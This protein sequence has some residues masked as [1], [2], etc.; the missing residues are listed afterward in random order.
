MSAKLSQSEG[1]ASCKPLFKAGILVRNSH[2]SVTSDWT[3]HFS[4]TWK[5]IVCHSDWM[6][7]FFFMCQKHISLSDWL[8]LICIHSFLVSIFSTY[9]TNIV[10][11]THNILLTTNSLPQPPISSPKTQTFFRILITEQAQFWK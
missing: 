3:Y 1:A 5:N 11:L 2:T 8:E 9:I 10:F 4:H 6:Y 7:H